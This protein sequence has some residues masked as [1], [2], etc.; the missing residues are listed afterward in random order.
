MNILT[1]S[2]L[3]SYRTCQRKC[4]LEYEMG[5][6]PIVNPGT[7]TKLGASGLCGGSE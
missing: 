1:H 5:I 7:R 6:R 2:R 4:E 3:A